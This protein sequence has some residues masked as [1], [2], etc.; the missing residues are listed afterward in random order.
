MNVAIVSD[1]PLKTGSNARN[2]P[3][4]YSSRLFSMDEVSSRNLQE[5][6]LLVIEL[7]NASGDHVENLKTA[8]AG[9][10]DLPKLCIVSKAN[11][12]EVVQAAA[13]GKV[14]TIERD[15]E[16]TTLVRKMRQMLKPNF[17]VMFPETTPDTTREAFLQTAACL[18]E[19]VLAAASS[20]PMPVRTL[21]RTLHHIYAALTKDGISAWLSAVQCHHSHTYRHSMMVAGLAATFAQTLGWSHK[22]QELVTF[23]GLMHDIGKTRIP[24]SILDKPGELTPEETELVRQHTLFG[25]EILKSRLEIPFEVKKMAV[26]HHE[27]LDGSGYPQGLAGD[28]IDTMVRVMTICDVFTAMTETRSYKD[29]IPP[30]NAY[31]ALSTMKTQLDQDL[32][33]AFQPVVLTVDLGAL[34]RTVETLF[35]KKSATGTTG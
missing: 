2:I 10:E 15:E 20:R 1:G 9:V 29:A 6:H 19:I 8:L 13:L 34:N 28:Q 26:Q 17:E 35:D 24:L 31:A 11:R 12:R 21:A 27:L 4:F 18:D 3:F 32:V 23:G 14:E 5:M 16:L 7:E 33:R 30:R 22:D 25:R